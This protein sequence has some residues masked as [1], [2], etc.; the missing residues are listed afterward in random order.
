MSSS[1]ARPSRWRE[2]DRHFRCA[3]SVPGVSRSSGEEEGRQQA[4]EASKEACWVMHADKTCHHR[5]PRPNR[6]RAECKIQLARASAPR[7]LRPHLACAPES[8]R[9]GLALPSLEHAYAW[10]VT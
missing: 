5:M 3:R 2:E 9:A 8:P 7:V 1:S 4:E 10:G 6:E